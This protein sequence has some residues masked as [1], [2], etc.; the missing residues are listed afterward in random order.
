MIN[1]QHDP[2]QEEVLAYKGDLMV[3]KGRRIGATHIMGIKAI[4]HLIHNKNTHPSSQ[5]VCVSLT[6]DQAQLI[7]CFALQYAED[8]YRRKNS[9]GYLCDYRQG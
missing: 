6:E 4:E 7:I 3:A 5:I 9:A 2:W 1:I 8:K